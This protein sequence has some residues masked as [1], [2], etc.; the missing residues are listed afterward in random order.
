MST[1]VDI[2][3]LKVNTL[4]GTASAVQD[5]Q[6]GQLVRGAC[7]SQVTSTNLPQISDHTDS[8]E[9]EIPLKSHP[10]TLMA[11]RKGKK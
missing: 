8:K 9:T 3:R 5:K 6:N 11:P 4:Y 1:I 2:R 10:S 7:T